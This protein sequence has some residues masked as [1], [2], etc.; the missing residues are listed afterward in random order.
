MKQNATRLWF[1]LLSHRLL[2]F[3]VHSNQPE[4]IS[5]I[6]NQFSLEWFG[7]NTY[8]YVRVVYTW[9]AN[10]LSSLRTT[11]RTHRYNPKNIPNIY[12]LGC[13][14]Q[15]KCCF[16]LFYLESFTGFSKRKKNNHRRCSMHI[17][18]M[19]L[20]HLTFCIRRIDTVFISFFHSLSF[21]RVAHIQ[22]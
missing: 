20:A 19:G 11:D 17:P 6:W 1:F 8:S 10:R 13:W 14:V 2:L 9:L 7:K 15:F 3:S 18:H 12:I 22:N 21:F 5:F 16:V 4:H